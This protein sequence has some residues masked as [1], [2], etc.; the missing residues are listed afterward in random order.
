M[1]AVGFGH[2]WS[3]EK[4][5]SRVD[6]QLRET[7]AIPSAMVFL[8]TF[9]AMLRGVLVGSNG[10]RGEDEKGKITLHLRM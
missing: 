8:L 1:S 2:A 6:S 5:T 3:A 10:R 7:L 4:A 9:A